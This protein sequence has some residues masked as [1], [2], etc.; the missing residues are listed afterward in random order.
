M[1]KYFVVREPSREGEVRKF[2]PEQ[3]V[4]LIEDGVFEGR[5]YVRLFVEKGCYTLYNVTMEQVVD[6]AMVEL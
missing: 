6:S 1:S 4:R 3:S 2:V 5:K